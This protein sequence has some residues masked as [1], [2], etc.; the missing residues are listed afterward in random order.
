LIKTLVRIKLLGTDDN[1][2]L[3][4]KLTQLSSGHEAA[5]LAAQTAKR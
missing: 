2:L 4:S 1:V 3:A 5:N